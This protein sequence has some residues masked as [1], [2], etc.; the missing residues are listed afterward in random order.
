MRGKSFVLSFLYLPFRDV[1][2]FYVC[3]CVSVCVC[4]GGGGCN[5][6]AEL[7]WKNFLPPAE[8]T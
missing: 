6:P 3:V 1:S 7:V 5:F 2:F 4:G 8:Y